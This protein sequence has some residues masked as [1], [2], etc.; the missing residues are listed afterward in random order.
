MDDGASGMWRS[1]L[2]VLIL[3]SL[4]AAAGCESDREVPTPV[5]PQPSET[6]VA[7]NSPSPVSPSPTRVPVAFTPTFLPTAVPNYGAVTFSTGFDE[8]SLSA[9]NPGKTFG[10][11][12]RVVFA[13][14]PYNNVVPNSTFD[15]EWYRNGVKVRSASDREPVWRGKS[16]E[17]LGYQALPAMPLDA[18]D[19]RFLVRVGTRTVVSD[20]FAIQQPS[21]TGTNTLTVFFT[22]Q[23][24]NPTGYVIDKQGIKHTPSSDLTISDFYVSIGDRL[25]LQ[26]DQRAFSLLFDCGTTPQLY[27][28]CDFSAESPATLPTALRKNGNGTA[29]LN[30]SRPGNWGDPRPDFEPQRYPAEPVLR[31]V[32]GD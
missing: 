27:S 31:I 13:S 32:M 5:P 4:L 22:V 30:I 10:Y 12:A 14:W 1:A 23:N 11:G 28:P 15:Y 29:T 8:Q 9:I 3:V 20:T 7:T 21:I 24:G 18:G 16:F 25:V 2:C 19:Y 26:T 6:F 17:A